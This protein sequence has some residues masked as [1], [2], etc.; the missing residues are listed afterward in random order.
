MSR[1][2]QMQ[3]PAPN[4]KSGLGAGAIIA[5]IIGVVVVVVLVC[6]GV[7]LAVLLPALGKARQSAQE[8]MTA[9]QTR[10]LVMVATIYAADNQDFLPTQADWTSQVQTYLGDPAGAAA[11]LDSP[12]VDGAGPDFIYTPPTPP[13]GATHVR[14]SDIRSP[15]QFI[16]MHEDLSR[17]PTRFTSV[18]V[19]MA[20][21]SVQMMDRATLE[22]MLAAQKQA[23]PPAAPGGTGGPG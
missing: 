1:T 9:A 21:G 12:R 23:A 17:L 4:A 14:M 10:Q 15:A 5:I 13:E 6:G 20:D 18:A 2:P 3:P 8:V 19:G 11:A 16:L 7:G 22:A